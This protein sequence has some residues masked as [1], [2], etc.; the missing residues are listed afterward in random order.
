MATRKRRA[1]EPGN[2]VRKN[3]D[4][5][6]DKLAAAQKALGT[7]TDTDTVDRA[8]DLAIGRKQI[9]DALD[10]ITARGGLELYDPEA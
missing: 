2:R 6:P 9:R 3:M 1:R 10:R 5:D 7:K 4:M 8:L